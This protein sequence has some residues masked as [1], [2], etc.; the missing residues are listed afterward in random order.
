MS[1]ALAIREEALVNANSQNGHGEELTPEVRFAELARLIRVALEDA[2]TRDDVS[3]VINQTRVAEAYAKVNLTEQHVRE[4]QEVHLWAARRAGEIRAHL[5]LAR[6]GTDPHISYSEIEQ[7]MKDGLGQK[8]VAKR[9]GCTLKAVKIAKRRGFRRPPYTDKSAGRQQ[10]DK[11]FGVSSNAGRSWQKLASLPEQEFSELIEETKRTGRSLSV[12]AICKVI[13]NT[14]RKKV[15]TGV[16][17]LKDGRFV[18]S[19]KERGTNRERFQT[20]R[21]GLTFDD[22]L[23]ERA[24]V[25][26]L[27]YGA[28]GKLPASSLSGAYE[29]L[30][31][32]RRTV[33]M[34][35]VTPQQRNVLA[36]PFSGRSLYEQI[37]DLCKR[38]VRATNVE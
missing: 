31:K 25:R 21:V 7:L 1:T 33:E 16:Y 27:L 36:C 17:E 23:A 32:V 8:A 18:I 26:R 10:F 20:L 2:Q 11:E 34:L 38:I 30:G 28:T 35:D 15:A 29:A 9:L 12:T 13:S 3:S 4:V 37:D 5:P 22:A 24:K 6:N 14:H 19:W